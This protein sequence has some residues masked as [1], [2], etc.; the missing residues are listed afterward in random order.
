[1]LGGVRPKLWGEMSATERMVSKLGYFQYNYG[2]DHPLTLAAASG[3]IVAFRRAGRRIT[4]MMDTVV[5]GIVDG[6]DTPEEGP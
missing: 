6:R 3:D 2:F 4:E 1:M 5:V